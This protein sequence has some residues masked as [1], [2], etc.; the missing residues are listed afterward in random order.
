MDKE[1]IIGYSN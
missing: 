1:S